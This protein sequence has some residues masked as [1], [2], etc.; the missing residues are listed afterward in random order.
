LDSHIENGEIDPNQYYPEIF[1]ASKVNGVL[2]S[3]PNIPT[4]RAIFYNKTLLDNVPY[5]KDDWMYDD[6]LSAAQKLTG[7]GVYGFV[8]EAKNTYH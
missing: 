6:F 1:N 4:T 5:P 8:T 3:I 7:N 2:Y